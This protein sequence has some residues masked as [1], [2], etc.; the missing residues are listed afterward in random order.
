MSLSSSGFSEEVVEAAA[1]AAAAAVEFEAGFESPLVA[2]RFDD[3]ASI[4]GVVV[5]VGCNEMRMIANENFRPEVLRA[6][7]PFHN[8]HNVS[9]MHSR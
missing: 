5:T 9:M 8:S 2:G 3:V 6:P 1:A 7:A 4:V